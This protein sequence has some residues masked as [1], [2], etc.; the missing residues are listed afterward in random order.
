MGSFA[1]EEGPYAASLPFC[2]NAHWTGGALAPGEMDRD[3]SWKTV[4]VLGLGG[5]L[6]SACALEPA[7]SGAETLDELVVNDPDFTFATSKT[8]RLELQASGDVAGGHAIEVS[9]AD[10]R[11]IL[12]GAVLGNATVDLPVAAAHSRTLRVRLGRD[13]AEQTVE[14]GVDNRAKA[15]F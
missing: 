5:V 8:V 6:A 12:K 14:V 4:L 1:S 15:E 13:A 3:M 7:D 9:D 10:G 2:A 11:R